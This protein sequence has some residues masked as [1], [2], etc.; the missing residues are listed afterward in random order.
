MNS[1]SINRTKNLVINNQK[2]R[3]AHICS[4]GISGAPLNITS[5]F[6]FAGE[7]P[8]PAAAN[9]PKLGEVHQARHA[10]LL[11]PA[12]HGRAETLGQVLLPYLGHRDDAHPFRKPLM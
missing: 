4:P 9:V 8:V 5:N 1:A 2:P 7:R 10:E 12:A 11:P 6:P 3:F